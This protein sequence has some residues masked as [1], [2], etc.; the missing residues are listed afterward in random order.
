MEAIGFSK[1]AVKVYQI[2]HLM[3][4]KIAGFTVIAE[5]PSDNT[6]ITVFTKD[7]YQNPSC[8]S[9]AWSTFVIQFSFLF[10]F[11]LSSHNLW[12]QL[13]YWNHNFVCIFPRNR[14]SNICR[15]SFQGKGST[16]RKLTRIHQE[17]S[18]MLI[19]IYDDYLF[20]FENCVRLCQVALVF[21]NFTMFRRLTCFR[22]QLKGRGRGENILK[23][24]F[25][26]ILSP[27]FISRRKL[28]KLPKRSIIYVYFRQ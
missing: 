22:H 2:I 18:D 8:A 3:S 9:S 6:E 28:T 11:M 25:S 23:A 14:G 27:T 1:F 17:D 13:T 7:T 16:V 12:S 19:L 26:R 24:K 10:L 15:R 21:L 4:Q 20:F 5:R